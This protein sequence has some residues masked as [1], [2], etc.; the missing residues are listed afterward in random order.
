MINFLIGKY[1]N[2]RAE[3][4]DAEKQAKRSEIGRMTGIRRLSVRLERILVSQFG[5]AAS[6]RRVFGPA[7]HGTTVAQ[8][9]TVR[10]NITPTKF[11]PPFVGGS[12]CVPYS[13]LPR[14]F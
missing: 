3:R 5:H 14:S 2:L 9:T 13:F 11:V 7:F 8:S 10:P 1:R 12:L 4:G 6:Q